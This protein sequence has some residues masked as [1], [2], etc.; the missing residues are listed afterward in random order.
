M[1]REYTWLDEKYYQIPNVV[2]M[3]L[4]DAQKALKGYKIEYNGS[5]NKVIYQSPKANYY[6][7]EGSTVILMLN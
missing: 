3:K 1:P 2:G 7:K 6:V 4:S 5:G